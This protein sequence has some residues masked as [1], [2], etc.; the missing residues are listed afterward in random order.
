MII[1]N[2]Q[3]SYDVRIKYSIDSDSVKALK[4]GALFRGAVCDFFYVE[5]RYFDTPD[6]A[7]RKNGFLL[8]VRT[9]EG[10][11]TQRA[12]YQSTGRSNPG[13][14]SS[15]SWKLEHASP[16]CRPLLSAGSF[17]FPHVNDQD[18]KTVFSI[19]YVRETLVHYEQTSRIRVVLDHGNIFIGTSGKSLNELELILEEGSEYD[20][21]M[22]S[23]WLEKN[24]KVKPVH[25]SKAERGYLFLNSLAESNDTTSARE[26]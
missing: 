5:D 4:K 18:L 20:R 7:L 25:G 19:S 17:N 11:I 6:K 13:V 2:S 21:F 1:P 15:Y 22:L 10:E 8:R 12:S 26:P 23:G 16:D 14:K 3:F 24:Y 9:C